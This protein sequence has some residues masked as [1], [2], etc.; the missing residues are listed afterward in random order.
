MNSLNTPYHDKADLFVSVEDIK[1]LF[2]M[3]AET[4]ELMQNVLHKLSIPPEILNTP[5]DR[6]ISLTTYF[7]I[8]SALSDALNDETCHLSAR[9]LMP[10]TTSFIL[11]SISSCTNLMDAM[12]LIAKSYNILHGGP[13]NRVEE[14]DGDLWY[15]I[16][17]SNFPYRMQNSEYIHFTMECILIFLHGMLSFVS[18]DT[19]FPYVR[20]LHTKRSHGTLK[21]T[22][23]SFWTVPTRYQS[24]AYA[25]IY[26]G[27]V[28]N[29]PI[30]IKQGHIPSSKEVYSK[31][32]SLVEQRI[33]STSSALTITARVHEAIEQGM[34]N[35]NDVAD[36]MGFSVATLRRRLSDENTSFR[37]IYHTV[38]NQMAQQ[39]LTQD[40]HVNDI[41]EE[42][43]FSDFR[44]FTRAFKNW[45]GVTPAQYK[46]AKKHN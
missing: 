24:P 31:I 26:D 44:S 39:R 27:A 3:E 16:D 8:I 2:D 7:K 28:T 32:I 5:E 18:P 15:I 34:Q 19:L 13:Y 29:F 11:S 25:L 37:S 36:H 22:H 41:A 9:H 33:V 30:N 42:L 17:D 43:G 1:P 21:S 14:K 6:S 20:K 38:L 46:T 23:L 45:N 10:G 40:Y 35:Q 4:K 12:K